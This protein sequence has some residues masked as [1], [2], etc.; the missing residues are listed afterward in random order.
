MARTTDDPLS[1]TLV[2]L[3]QIREA[4]LD[5]VAEAAWQTAREALAVVQEEREILLGIAQDGRELVSLLDQYQAALD[6]QDKGLVADLEQARGEAEDA[7]AASLAR[8]HVRLDDEP[9]LSGDAA[10]VAALD[11]VAANDDEEPA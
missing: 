7:L 8:L 4:G 2:A 3:D 11:R 9:V 10:Y 1:L 6:A 5:P